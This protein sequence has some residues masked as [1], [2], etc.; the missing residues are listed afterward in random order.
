M[1]CISYR[2]FFRVQEDRPISRPCP[3]RPKAEENREFEQNC[4]GEGEGAA[5]VCACTWR[6]PDL[7]LQLHENPNTY[8]E[9]RSVKIPALHIYI[10]ICIEI[11]SCAYAYIYIYLASIPLDSLTAKFMVQLSLLWLQRWEVHRPGAGAEAMPPGGPAV[12]SVTEGRLPSLHWILSPCLC[13][14]DFRVALSPCVCPCSA[15]RP[16]SAR[17]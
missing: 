17:A 8:A 6:V 4:R 1:S 9:H 16:P 15:C 13:I 10:Y 5:N 3:R 2:N 7:L 12:G 14:S 11:W